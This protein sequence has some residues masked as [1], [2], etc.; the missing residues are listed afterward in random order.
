MIHNCTKQKLNTKSSTES[1]V[2]GV[3]DFLP[4]TIWASYFLKAQGYKLNRNIFYK[5]NTSAIKMLKNGKESCGSK[6]RHIHIRYFFT[7]DVIERENMEIKHCPTEQMIAD[8]YTKPIQGKQFYK[9]RNIIMGHDTIPVEECV[10]TSDK[11][12]TGTSTNRS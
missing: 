2:V 11:M 9:L 3:S 8:F 10:G 7:K 5:D 1:E 6:S 12:T 4:Y